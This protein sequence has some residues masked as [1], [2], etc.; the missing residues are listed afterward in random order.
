MII[1]KRN[2]NLTPGYR[3]KWPFTVPEVTVQLWM[4]ENQKCF[5]LIHN[6]GGFALSGILESHGFGPLS[7][8]GIW[9]D[10]A[11]GGVHIVKG[12]RVVSTPTKK[13]L[14]PFFEYVQAMAARKIKAAGDAEGENVKEGENDGP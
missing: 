13:S 1:K 14:T 9:G 12:Q 10:D 4:V 7:K 8:S 6:F 5:S 11:P 3:G 2:F